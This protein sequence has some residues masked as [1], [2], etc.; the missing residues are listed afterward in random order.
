LE[1]PQNFAEVIVNHEVIIVHIHKQILPGHIGAKGP[2]LRYN[3]KGTPYCALAVETDKAGATGRST[4]RF[5]R[6]KS[7]DALPRI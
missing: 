5:T 7:P 1:L 6:S 4:R 2:E 3:A